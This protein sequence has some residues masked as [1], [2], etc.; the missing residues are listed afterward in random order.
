MHRRWP[1]ALLALLAAVALG[2]EKGASGGGTAT[3]PASTDL[4]S[5]IAALGDSI[6]AGYASC[7]TLVACHLNS[8][9]TGTGLRVDSHYRRIQRA[10]AAIRGRAHTLA[11][12]GARAGQLPGQ[13]R[14]AVRAG[15]QY[16]TVLV[17]AN[18][19]CR[20]AVA[21]MTPPATFRDQ[22][23]DALGVLRD[24]LPR[25]QVL[26]VAVPDLYRLWEIGHTDTRAVRAWSLGVCPTLLARPTSSAGADVARRRAVRDRV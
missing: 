16:V 6:S 23:D 18:D 21:D 13:A 1:A 25:T 14:A 12:P 8:W 3:G 19:A 20:G 15:V 11:V 2:C 5:S 7:L 22:I 10:N 24:G 17:G 4:P 26:V 9:S